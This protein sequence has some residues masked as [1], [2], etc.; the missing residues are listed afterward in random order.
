MQAKLRLVKGKPQD[1]TVDIPLG[2]L[3]VGRDPESD[4]IIAVASVSRHHCEI[5]NE[6]SRLV[7][8]DK[9][10]GNGTLV[11]GQKVQEQV[12]NAGD[13]IQIGPLAF[14]V[15]IEG[16]HPKPAAPAAPKAPVAAK[17]PVALKA[18]VAKPAAPVRPLLG[19]PAPAKTGPAP[20]KPKIPA[21][22]GK[23]PGPD[24]VLASLERLAGG[25]KKKPGAAAPPGQK[26]GDDVL[27]ISDEDLLDTDK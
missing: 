3:K 26:K 21:P 23:R 8:R 15:E 14:A 2:T 5:V 18:P 22:P 25:P 16:V 6:E 4:L 17:A 11:N 10:S 27:E 13:E 24:D 1:K 7:L 9:G 19:K 20:A 12:L